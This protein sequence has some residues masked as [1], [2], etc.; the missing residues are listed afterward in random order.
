MKYLRQDI[1]PAR[2]GITGDYGVYVKTLNRSKAGVEVAPIDDAYGQTADTVY[3]GRYYVL[4]YFNPEKH[5]CIGDLVNTIAHECTHAWQMVRKHMD[6]DQNQGDETEAY[7]IGWLTER[8][9]KAVV[10][11]LAKLHYVP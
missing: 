8:A 6:E 9:L 5:N 4:M 7:M 2:F 10:P 3:R 1:F 11:E